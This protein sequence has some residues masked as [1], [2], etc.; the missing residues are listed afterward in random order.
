MATTPQY[1]A[2]PTSQYTDDIA[3]APGDLEHHH[4]LSPISTRSS[5][6][7]SNHY[8]FPWP[9]STHLQYGTPGG[10]SY[11]SLSDFSP[12]FPDSPSLPRNSL[13]YRCD[14]PNS[15]YAANFSTLALNLGSTFPNPQGAEE[16]S[17]HNA[18]PDVMNHDFPAAEALLKPGGS[19]KPYFCTYCAETGKTTFFT[20]KS[21]WKKHQQ[22]YHESNKEY[23][24]RIN[25]CSQIFNHHHKYKRHWVKQHESLAGFSV[26]E[27][28]KQLPQKKVFG[29]GFTRC[30]QV[31]YEWDKY[32][33]HVA[34]H[35]KREGLKPSDWSYSNTFRNLLRQ[36]LIRKISKEELEEFCR[37]SKISRSSLCWSLSNTRELRENLGCSIFYPNPKEFVQ[38]AIRASTLPNPAA[39]LPNE[40]M[41]SGYD[42]MPSADALGLPQTQDLAIDNSEDL[43]SY[44][45]S[46]HSQLSPRLQMAFENQHH[47]LSPYIMGFPIPHSS[48]YGHGPGGYY[49]TQREMGPP[50]IHPMLVENPPS[51]HFQVQAESDM[52]S[53]DSQFQYSQ[54]VPPE[55]SNQEQLI[56]PPEQGRYYY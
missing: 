20:A 55:Y 26:E 45:Q 19:E 48:N 10:S 8:P 56:Y 46:N 43:D 30:K 35:M 42:S 17:Y 49:H 34:D 39:A 18:S 12:S 5:A 1:Y 16:T 14:P 44:Y 28:V 11:T 53:Q 22:N 21:D 3:R 40:F 29:C 13:G 32:C 50:L 24:C 23:R 2:P 27:V 38:N 31:S 6:S 25:D 4:S 47:S 52:D 51:Q 36:E 33:N 15:N 41:I 37:L 54:Y 9:D 7:P